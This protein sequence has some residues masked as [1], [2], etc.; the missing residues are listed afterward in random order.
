MWHIQTL[1]FAGC[2]A[3]LGFVFERF[4][5]CGMELFFT[6]QF[7]PRQTPPFGMKYTY[8]EC[9]CHHECR[10]DSLRDCRSFNGGK[11]DNSMMG[12]QREKWRCI[13]I[14]ILMCGTCVA[15]SDRDLECKIR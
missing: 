9:S 15:L 14:N 8:K 3:S 1:M 12:C 4:Q 6:E 5:P 7:P 13:A 10:G 2:G 11:K